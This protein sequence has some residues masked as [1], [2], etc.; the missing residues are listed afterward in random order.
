M[1]EID[2]AIHK[3]TQS[4]LE[5]VFQVAGRSIPHHHAYPLYA[6][7]CQQAPNLHDT[8]LRYQMR[9]L[10]VLK[11][12]AGKHIGQVPSGAV[13]R[14]RVQTQDFPH[15][16]MLTGQT[17]D[18]AGHPLCL[19]SPTVQRLNPGGTLLSHMVTIKG[20]SEPEPFLQAVQRQLGERG[21]NATPTIPTDSHGH[22]QRRILQI[23]D[24][25]V[26]GF[27][28]QVSGLTAENSLLLQSVGLG[29]RS[30]LGCGYFQAIQLNGDHRGRND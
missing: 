9:S 29:G 17:L 11:A 16:L 25:Q 10:P 6:A 14:F 26:V 3:T 2:D 21:I 4:T 23:K 7:L 20:F 18:V 15:F 5:L 27:P 24:K 1:N 28:V 8:D 30:K 13:L 22:P 12:K 19:G